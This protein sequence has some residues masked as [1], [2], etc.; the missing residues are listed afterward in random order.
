MTED[1]GWTIGRHLQ[2]TAVLYEYTSYATLR[3]A[4]ER[5]CVSVTMRE[6]PDRS[7]SLCI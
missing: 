7:D 2:N 4:D 1:D 3:C 6:S 5:R